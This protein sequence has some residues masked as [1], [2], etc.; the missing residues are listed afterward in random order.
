MQKI[1]SELISPTIPE[2]GRSDYKL[3]KD[4]TD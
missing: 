1:K 2:L 4:K 3:S